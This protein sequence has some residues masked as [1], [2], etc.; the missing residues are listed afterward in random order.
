[1]HAFRLVETRHAVTAFSGEG[2][3]IFPGRFHRAGTRVVYTAATLSLA[4]LELLARFEPED[5][6]ADFVSIEVVVPDELPLAKIAPSELPDGWRAFPPL[7]ATQEL[8][9]RWAKDGRTVA[10]AVPSAL[11]PSEMNYLLNP[12]HPAFR[13]IKIG[14][15]EPFYFDPRLRQR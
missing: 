1:M 7:P 3:R 6:T 15:P 12:Q 5:L 4:A 11:V 10:L 8:G 13:R 2:A 14:K 9:T